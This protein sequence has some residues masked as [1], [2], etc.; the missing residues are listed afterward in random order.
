MNCFFETYLRT[1]QL[2]YLYK[3]ATQHKIQTM[4]SADATRQIKMLTHNWADVSED[5]MTNVMMATKKRDPVYYGYIIIPEIFADAVVERI[6]TCD[7]QTDTYY[8]QFILKFALDFA[9]YDII[10]R[11]VMFWGWEEKAI[12]AA[13]AEVERALLLENE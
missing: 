3:M 7:V 9:C 11:H 8:E 10:G 5:I 1:T 13:I 4:K 2:N 12:A 6:L